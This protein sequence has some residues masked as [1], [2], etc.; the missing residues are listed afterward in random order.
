MICAQGGLHEFEIRR[1]EQGENGGKK[2]A[3]RI[4]NLSIA[5]ILPDDDGHRLALYGIVCQI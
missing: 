5:T 1:A 2:T 3:L 4:E